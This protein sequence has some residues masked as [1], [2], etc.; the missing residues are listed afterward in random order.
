MKILDASSFLCESS[1]LAR[2]PRM[3]V[4]PHSSSDRSYGSFGPP[5][6]NHSH[7]PSFISSMQLSVLTCSPPCSI[8]VMEYFFFLFSV[9][10]ESFLCKGIKII[11]DGNIATISQFMLT[12]L[13][14]NS[15][16]SSLA[17]PKMLTSSLNV[18]PTAPAAIFS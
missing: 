2:F 10:C 18:I 13:I 7:P 16:A 6:K 17:F 14:C 15:S 8:C 3:Y 9:S 11:R 12:S 5:I 4:R 1:E